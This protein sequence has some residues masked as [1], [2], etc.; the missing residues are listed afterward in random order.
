MQCSSS[1]VFGHERY[2]SNMLAH[3]VSI[4]WNRQQVDKINLRY[5]GGWNKLMENSSLAYIHSTVIQISVGFHFICH[6]LHVQEVIIEDTI[7]VCVLSL[8]IQTS[9]FQGWYYSAFPSGN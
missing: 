2:Y 6:E 8:F 7:S 1:A 5:K 9:S 4:N 3:V